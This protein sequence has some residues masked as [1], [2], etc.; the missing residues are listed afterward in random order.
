MSNPYSNPYP[1]QYQ[2]QQQYSY[3]DNYQQQQHQ[4]QQQQQ[5]EQQHNEYLLPSTIPDTNNL[6]PTEQRLSQV[7]RGAEYGEEQAI[8]Y[9]YEFYD[10]PHSEPIRNAYGGGAY[11][12]QPQTPLKDN[13][14]STI[15]GSSQTLNIDRNPSHPDNPDKYGRLQVEES[16]APP[17]SMPKN[18]R[19]PPTLYSPEVRKELDSLKSHRPWFLYVMTAI[20]VC[21][22]IG[23]LVFNQRVTG[24]F[25][26]TNPFNYMVGPAPGILIQ[27]GARFVP[28][29]RPGT[30]L[31]VPGRTIVCPD[32][33]ITNTTAF[34]PATGLQA[35]TCTA[36][37][38]C[39]FGG[40]N[41]AP[42]NQWY[43]FIIPIFLHGGVL[44]LLF[45]MLFQ[46]QTGFQLERDFGWWRIGL[47]YFISGVGGFIFGGNFN[48]LTPSVGCSGALFG[49]VACLVIDLFQ[50]WRIIA[51]PWW[52]LIKLSIT[53]IVSLLIGMLPYIDN[54]AHIGGFF[55]GLLAGLI[56]MPTI[57]Y[58]KWD[59]RVKTGLLV[60]SIP[61]LIVIFVLML[62]GFYVGG[63]DSCPWCK[64]LNC[65]PGLPWCEEKWT[66][67]I[68]N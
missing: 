31:D 38:I 44:H 17:Q 18:E 20:Q 37:D 55:C 12:N 65:I 32:G 46:V 62:R 51:K 66:Q 43:R 21:V 9:N 34:N 52:E 59:G 10:R 7:Y 14:D 30:S 60:G 19:L 26:E 24:S 8:G 68:T 33:I 41:N 22:T 67:S 61:I 58:S 2:N 29:M 40:F 56:F 53:V 47:I 48:K 16:H 49:L 3:T 54:F 27:M 50:N 39:G 5:Q 23:S 6:A 35:S 57:H 64:Y 4:Q 15:P 1:S 28:C 42:P 25:I 13:I 36:E 63:S 11:N 45:N